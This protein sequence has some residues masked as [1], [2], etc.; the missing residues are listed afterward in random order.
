MQELEAKSVTSGGRDVKESNAG[1]PIAFR[2][3]FEGSTR[4][5]YSLVGLKP[6]GERK[7]PKTGLLGSKT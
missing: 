1:L 6:R 5:P 2:I 4:Q 7:A 3:E